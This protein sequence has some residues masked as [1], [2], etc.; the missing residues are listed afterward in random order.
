MFGFWVWVVLFWCGWVGFD[1]PWWAFL[2]CGVS[3][4][5]C[6][7]YGLD[8]R[9]R[10]NIVWSGWRWFKFLYLVWW[11]LWIVRLLVG[12]MLWVY[13]GLADAWLL[14][15]LG[16]DLCRVLN[17]CLC[18]FGGCVCCLGCYWSVWLISL[19]FG[20]LL[21]GSLCVLVCGCFVVS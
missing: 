19:V 1:L 16:F 6:I 12:L 17:A 3:D 2:L 14:C 18:R 9:I 20:F 10:F 21:V 11:V 8:G 4:L 7:W 15:I 13:V 5:G